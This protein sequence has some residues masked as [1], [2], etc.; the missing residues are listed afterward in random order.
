[1]TA[2]A[3]AASAAAAA[4]AAAVSEEL[5]RGV[6]AGQPRPIGRAISEV[7]RDSG[8]VP[9]I[10]RLLFARTGRA[11][12]LGITGPPGAGKSTLLSALTAAW[13]ADGRS[14]AVLAVDPSSKRSGGSL[15]GDRARIEADPA[16]RALFIR[17]TGLG[18]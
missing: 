18:V 4:A 17:S 1:M 14:V 8:A 16:D 2:A 7:E 6:L 11:R 15:L 3:G 13:R 9:G 10:L 5:A 12:I